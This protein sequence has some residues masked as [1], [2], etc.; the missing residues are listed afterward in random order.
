MT[1]GQ[2]LEILQKF[3]KGASVLISIDHVPVI[4]DRIDPEYIYENADGQ[5]VINAFYSG[6][7]WN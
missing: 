4:G 2:L 6:Q 7:G 1:V 3:D 5:L